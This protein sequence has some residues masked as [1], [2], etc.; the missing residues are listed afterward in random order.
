M[1]RARRARAG[2]YES[3]KPGDYSARDAFAEARRHFIERERDTKARYAEMRKI[4]TSV[5]WARNLARNGEPGE[6]EAYCEAAGIRL[7]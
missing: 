3:R 6:A 7:D 4:P 2:A 1:A 5:L